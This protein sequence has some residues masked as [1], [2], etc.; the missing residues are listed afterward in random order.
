M[1]AL[2]CMIV[3]G[4]HTRLKVY[5][6][7]P[8]FDIF[9]CISGEI[10][11]PEFQHFGNKQLGTREIRIPFASEHRIRLERNDSGRHSALILVECYAPRNENFSHGVV[12]FMNDTEDRFVASN[13]DLHLL[14][15]FYQPEHAAISEGGSPHDVTSFF[16]KAR[17]QATQ[18]RVYRQNY[19]KSQ[20]SKNGDGTFNETKEAGRHIVSLNGI[21]LMGNYKGDHGEAIRLLLIP[22]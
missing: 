3:G 18:C 14:R 22:Q 20:V 10:L 9:T 12:G 17:Y 15:G 8:H 6:G 2:H 4:K 21:Q 13:C 11:V 1:N 16:M 5:A 7:P 19:T